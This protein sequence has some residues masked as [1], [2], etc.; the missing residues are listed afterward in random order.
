MAAACNAPITAG[1][2]TGK[3]AAPHPPLGDEVKPPLRARV[4]AYPVEERYGY[5]WVFLG[6]MSGGQRPALP[7][8]LPD[9]ADG[10]TWRVVRL[11]RDWHANWARVHENLLD[12]S[13]LYLVHSFGRPGEMNLAETPW[14]GRV[15]QRFI[16]SHPY[17][18]AA[19]RAQ[20]SPMRE[21]VVTLDF[22]VIG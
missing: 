17:R 18:T 22:S 8:F 20:A 11:K 7:D 12:T 14:G 5:V 3:A 10:D 9:Y 6:D 13:H 15:V 4:D 21:S 1:S 2:S 16:A 19:N